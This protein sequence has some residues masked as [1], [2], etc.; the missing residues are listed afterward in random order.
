MLPVLSL[1]FLVFADDV[2]DRIGTRQARIGGAIALAVLAYSAYLQVQI[3]R[4][5]F[6][7]YYHA[8]AAVRSE[9]SIDYFYNHHH[10]VVVNDLIKHRSNL[11]GLAYYAELKRAEPETFA[12]RRAFILS[13]LE[14]G[15]LYWALPPEERRPPRRDLG[16]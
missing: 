9:D 8:R 16:P 4:M 12:Y 7:T 13:M 3:N 6:F 1:P 5:P 2:V 15:N 11:E 14:R 10:A